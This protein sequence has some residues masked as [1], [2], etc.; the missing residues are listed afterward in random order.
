MPEATPP[1]NGLH[2]AG[3]YTSDLERAAR[4]WSG[5]GFDVVARGAGR[6]VFLRAG[7]DLVLIFDPRT[8]IRSGAFPAHG[9]VGPG[10]IALDV[11]DADALDAWRR[12]L[13]AAGVEVEY[14]TAWP[15]GGRSLY[16]RD[17]DGNSIELITRGSWGF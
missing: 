15:T 10:H 16:F 4:F 12:H 5:L 6:H 13:A 9:A 1:L 8:T 14:E 11:P 17:P 7:R 3:L 2:E